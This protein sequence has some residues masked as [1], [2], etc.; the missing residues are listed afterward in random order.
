MVGE[1]ARTYLNNRSGQ[2][3]QQDLVA[4][5][6]EQENRIRKNHGCI[7]DTDILNFL[8]WA[9]VKYGHIP[10]E[11][12]ELWT[13]S[14]SRIYL[15]CK[16]DIPYVADPLRE[17]EHEREM[18]FERHLSGLISGNRV[19]EIIEGNFEERTVRAEKILSKYLTQSNN[20]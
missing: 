10:G 5:A 15:L 3:D 4:M 2:Y 18:L 16:P 7:A 14:D 19:Y 20:S 17:S 11:L 12:T 13:T 6:M 1:Y 8:I 9:E